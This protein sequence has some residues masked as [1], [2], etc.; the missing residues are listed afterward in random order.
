MKFASVPSGNQEER[1]KD[2]IGR[3]SNDVL[4]TCYVMLADRA[5]AEDAMQDTFLKVWR[6]MSR[7]D[8]RNDA[9]PKT[10]IMR[11]A[12]NTCK[13]YRRTAWMRGR[14]QTSTYDDLP[15]A[16]CPVTEVSR[17]LFLTVLTL[18]DK[19]KQVVLL[20]HYQELTMEETAHALGVSRPAVS[21][22]L[23][24]AYALLRISLEGGQEI[25]AYH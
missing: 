2:W 5:L 11:I 12:I 16:L 8:G 25:E 15:D 9:S 13:D 23:Q 4:R 10:W 7:Y 20:Y 21:R 22:R 18:P 6:G 14:A 24:K 17:E 19:Y 3:Y 1:L